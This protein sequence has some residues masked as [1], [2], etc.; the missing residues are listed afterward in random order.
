[1]KKIK[2]FFRIVKYEFIRLTRNK[3]VAVMMCLFMFVLLF[4]LSQV[5]FDIKSYPIAICT[6]G[7]NSEEM[8]EIG[9]IVDEISFENIIYVDNV[10]EGKNLVNSNRACF[11]ITFDTST[12]PTTAIFHYDQ[13]S[14]FAKMVKEEIIN[15]SNEQ[16]YKSISNFLKSYGISINESYFNLITFQG[17]SDKTVTFRQMMFSIE[18]AII[19][20][21]ILMLGLAYSMARDN[22]TKVSNN[23]TYMPIGVNKY[24]LSKVF[25][26]FVIG[27][28]QLIIALICGSIF[29]KIDYAINPVAILSISTLFILAVIMQGLVFSSCK[30]QIAT[31]FLSMVSIILP[32]FSLMFAYIYNL[33]IIIQFI[34]LCLPITPFI[35]FMNGMVF[36]G[37]IIWS[38]L[39][40]FILQILVYYII[41]LIILKRKI[42]R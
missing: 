8:K 19:S 30:S 31:I 22:E 21:I 41:A 37:I 34:L 25:V 42:K 32:L 9:F 33:P 35:E 12:S 5:K 26:Y 15:K 1:M 38:D 36:N 18:M 7:I 24:L 16:A 39:V 28:Y 2:S 14:V 13:S 3:F 23:L 4:L 20:T 27:L 40:I 17:T 10:E 29:F 11:L 6:N